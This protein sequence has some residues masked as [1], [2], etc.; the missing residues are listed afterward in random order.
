MPATS[1]LAYPHVPG[2]ASHSG[3]LNQ[4][5]SAIPRVSDGTSAPSG[6]GIVTPGDLDVQRPVQKG[7]STPDCT[8]SVG[9]AG[10]ALVRAKLAREQ[11]SKCRLCAHLCEANRLAGETGPC[12]AGAEAR[13]FSVQP[14]VSDEVELVPTFA[15]ALSGCDLRC[16]FCITAQGSWNARF[17]A[18]AE[19]EKL[20]RQALAALAEG[21]KTVMILG[22]EPTIHLPTALEIVARLPDSVR[23]VWKTN[24]RASSEALELLAGMFDVWL[25]DY[26]FGNADC[27][28]KLVDVPN[29][30]AAV[31]QNLLWAA[32]HGELIVRHLVMPGHVE[33]CWRPVARW[34][35]EELPGTKVNLRTGFW[36]ARFPTAWPELKRTV[37]AEEAQRA[38]QI[39]SEF[40][41]RL[42]S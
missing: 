33:C 6:T 26:K 38:R 17:G 35:A 9:R 15:I 11:L 1:H 27:A 23:L 14:E 41:L 30:E 28:R 18:Q 32:Q 31:R 16:P 3:S 24:G 7:L 5:M 20:A 37:S 10:R 34:L 19:P 29:Y 4:Q 12:K 39:A 21:A 2:L 36:P 25:V 8:T 42:I 40:N 13:V 22:G